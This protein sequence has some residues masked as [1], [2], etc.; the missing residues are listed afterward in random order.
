MAPM[1]WQTPEEINPAIFARASSSVPLFFQPYLIN[2]VSNINGGKIN[3][4]TLADF[5]ADLPKNV[6]FTDGGMLSNFPI[7]LFNRI[8]VP[9]APTFGAIFGSRNRIVKATTNIVNF[10]ENMY[11]AQQHYLSYEFIFQHPLYQRLITNIPTEKYHWLDFNMSDE[12]KLGLFSEGVTAGYKFLENF[13]WL[14]YKE[15]RASEYE[16]VKTAL[17]KPEDE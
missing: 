7:D 14:L 13:D 11:G 8:G 15:M 6:L 2:E 1:Y 10:L 12:D 16:M 9:R 5:D 4:K 3:W 17:L